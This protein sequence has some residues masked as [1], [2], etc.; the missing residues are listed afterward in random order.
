M[1]ANLAISSTTQ[2]HTLIPPW[3]D[4]LKNIYHNQNISTS[5]KVE[6]PNKNYIC[7]SETV[8]TCAFVSW[9]FWKL[10]SKWAHPEPL[11]ILSYPS[12]A[13]FC[14][15][16]E[17]HGHCMGDVQVTGSQLT[18]VFYLRLKVFIAKPKRGIELHL[19]F[20]CC[21]SVSLQLRHQIITLVWF[22]SILCWYQYSLKLLLMQC[23]G[24]P[25]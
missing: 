11:V 25:C 10:N 20:N 17:V 1:H 3:A 8:V 24:W 4:P 15:Y 13:P 12:W 5:S 21:Y 9:R 6:R 2:Q 23:Q 7:F 22:D 18:F 16:F 19:W 14:K